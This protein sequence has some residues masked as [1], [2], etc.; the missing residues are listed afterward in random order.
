[1]KKLFRIGTILVIFLLI[2]FMSQAQ[3][4]PGTNAGGSPV[5]GG[6]IGGSAPIGNGIVLLLTMAIGY[7]SKKM[8]NARKMLIK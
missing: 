1:M 5:G 4:N 6:P 2:G 8:Y 7:G 3:P